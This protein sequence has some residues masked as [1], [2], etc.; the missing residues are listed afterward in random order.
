MSK[1]EEIKQELAIFV[2]N[3]GINISAVPLIEKLIENNV[4]YDEADQFCEEHFMSNVIANHYKNFYNYILIKKEAENSP[5]TTSDSINAKK[6][7]LDIRQQLDILE[8]LI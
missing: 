4:S 7:I 3:E 2:E 1:I 6:I 8:K 5:V